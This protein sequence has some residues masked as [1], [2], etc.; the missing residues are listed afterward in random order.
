MI[1]KN[2]HFSQKGYSVFEI[3]VVVTI[4]VLIVAVANQAFFISLRGQNKSEATVNTKQNANYIVSVIERALHSSTQV[5]SCTAT[6]IT[7][8]DSIGKSQSFSCT[9]GA[10]L[11][12]GAALTTTDVTVSNCSF[13]C[14]QEGG[15]KTVVVSMN[16]SQAGTNLRVDQTAST[17]IQ[18]RI[19]LRN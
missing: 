2:K 6:S 4:F 19:R 16:F 17:Q 18:T 11:S 1:A 14:V 13:S 9:N 12:S 8:T 5:S 3:L 15:S 10:V 7:Y